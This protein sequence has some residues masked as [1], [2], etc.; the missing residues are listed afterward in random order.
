[1][2][3]D[4]A[5]SKTLQKVVIRQIVY[6]PCVEYFNFELSITIY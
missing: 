2:N 4:V 6:K 3:Y 5:E 1:M